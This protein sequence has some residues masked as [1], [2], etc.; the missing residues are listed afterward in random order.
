[1]RA[2]MSRSRGMAGAQAGR[3]RIEG[4]GDAAAGGVR[5]APDSMEA[6]FALAMALERAG[7]L[8]EAIQSFRAAKRLRPDLTRW[9]YDIAS[10]SGEPPPAAAPKD[11][12]VSLFSEYAP[13]FE[14]H[15]RNVLQYRVPELI[16]AAV[17]ESGPV[18]EMDVLD[19]GCGTGLVGEVI[20]PM[21][22]SLVGVDLSPQM[23]KA[24]RARGG[25]DELVEGE[26]VDYLKSARGQFDLVMA[27]D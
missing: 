23:L 13:S 18:S 10:L 3:R 21:A 25:Y 17:K 6:H 26:I 11:Y 24:A 22:R 9:E 12:V 8:N 4:G 27:G 14:H 15:L 1:M 7:R 20:R 5:L 19:L 16:A 2:V